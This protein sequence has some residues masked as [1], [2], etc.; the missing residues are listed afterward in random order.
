MA[1]VVILDI[2][3]IQKYIFASNKLKENIG[4]SLIISGIFKE[5]IKSPYNEYFESALKN[6]YEGGGNVVLIFK[7]IGKEKVL[8]VIRE[9]TFRILEKYPGIDLGVGIDFGFAGNLDKA[10]AELQISKNKFIPIST[11]P[12]HG[13]TAECN[14]TGLSSEIFYESNKQSSYISY[15]SYIKLK[16]LDEIKSEKGSDFMQNILSDSGL[17][18]EYTFT[19]E[20][21]KLG[22]KKGEDSH[23]AFVAIDG[24]SMSDRFMKC[25]DLSAK[26]QL[27][28][29]LKEAVKNSFI[30]LLKI[31]D[32]EFKEID[33]E[34]NIKYENGKKILPVR[35]IILGGDDVSFI[36][37][38]SMGIYFASR[39]LKFFAE[40]TVSDGL[41]LSACAGVAIAH[42]KYPIYRI[43]KIAE[44]LLSGA[45]DK[46]KKEQDEENDSGSYIDFQM[47]Y[48]GIFGEL[49]EIRKNHYDNIYGKMYMRPYKIEDIESLIKPVEKMHRLA[50]SKI[51]DIRVVLNKTE[52]ERSNFIEHMKMRAGADEN[53]YSGAKSFS[54]PYEILG[55][56]YEQ[57]FYANNATPYFDIIELLEILPEYV[58]KR[59]SLNG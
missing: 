51:K 27:S 53:S 26:K 21:E 41:P 57:D 10:Y 3:S 47:F 45:K 11:I 34:L 12:S 52:S 13:I 38:G 6:G 48:S 46:R 29:T 22:S 37:E 8:E 4:A 5:K 42:A 39:F 24:N 20:L 14:R 56:K 17:D 25:N 54:I 40:Q 15:S 36:C 16:K 9:F 50:E 19:D 2:M 1:I 7:D 18:G 59:G 23:I 43:Q 30:G 55:Q 49:G 35:P 31:I 28:D 32:E 44:E 33:E 58:I